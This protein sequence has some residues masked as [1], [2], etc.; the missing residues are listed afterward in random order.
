MAIETR[1]PIFP[2]DVLIHMSSV[3][4]ISIMIYG[5]VA[6]FCNHSIIRGMCV[7]IRI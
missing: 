3:N 7:L 2:K 5:Y 6:L 1:F 4:Q